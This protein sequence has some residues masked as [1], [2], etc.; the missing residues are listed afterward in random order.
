MAEISFHRHM[1]KKKRR[2]IAQVWLE[3][4]ICFYSEMYCWE[5]SSL[6]VILV[7][8]GIKSRHFFTA[9]LSNKIHLLKNIFIFSS[10]KEH[11]LLYF[12]NILPFILCTVAQ[13]LKSI[14]LATPMSWV[15]FLGNTQSLL[16]KYIHRMKSKLLWKK[17]KMQCIN[18]CFI[19]WCHQCWLN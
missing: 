12:I 9:W 8:T 16:A 15:W 19:K 3:K 17:A 10:R 5:Y 4:C 2:K 14:V 18:I 13:V 6:N 11:L 7:R 1:Q